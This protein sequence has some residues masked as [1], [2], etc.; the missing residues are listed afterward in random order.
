VL[1]DVGRGLHGK[2][3]PPLNTPDISRSLTNLGSVTLSPGLVP[4]MQKS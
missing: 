1:C 2:H 4:P 3:G